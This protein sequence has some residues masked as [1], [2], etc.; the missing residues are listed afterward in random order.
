MKTVVSVM[1]WREVRVGLGAREE[2]EA[3]VATMVRFKAMPAAGMVRFASPVSVRAP[4]CSAVQARAVGGTR[5]AGE[6]CAA[7]FKLSSHA[8]ATSALV[9]QTEF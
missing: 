7:W 2:K 9:P 5:Q 4:H 6:F 1:S 8:T 3:S